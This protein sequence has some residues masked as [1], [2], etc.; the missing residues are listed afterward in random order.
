[1]SRLHCQL[2]PTLV[3]LVPGV[4]QSE[5]SGTSS[6]TLELRPP[7]TCPAPTCCPA[8]GL[9]G[10]GGPDVLLPGGPPLGGGPLLWGPLELGGGPLEPLA[11]LLVLNPSCRRSRAW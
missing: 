2:A 8:Q 6:C 7:H 5:G 3:H 10:G 11:G 1:V 4:Q 9:G